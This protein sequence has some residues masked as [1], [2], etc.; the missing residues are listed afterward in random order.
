MKRKKSISRTEL[1]EKKRTRIDEKKHEIK[2]HFMEVFISPEYDKF[3][4]KNMKHITRRL[5]H[6]EEKLEDHADFLQDI[7]HDFK[8]FL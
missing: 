4:Q 8:K 3:I 1:L 5:D 6:L 2:D 7:F